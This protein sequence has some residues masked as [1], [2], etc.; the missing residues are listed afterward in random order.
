MTADAMVLAAPGG[1]AHTLKLL[2]TWSVVVSKPISPADIKAGSYI[3]TTNYAKPDGTGTSVEV[4]VS[5]P[6]QG[7][8]G[9]DFVMDAAAGT[10]MTNGTVTTVAKSEGGRVLA[11]NYGPGVRR[12]TVPDNVPV[13]LNTPGDRALVA[14]GQS[15]RVVTFTPAGG[16]AS[17]QFVTVGEKG[18]P[19]PS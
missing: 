15:V 17:R 10:T 8:P 16:G 7:G 11:V 19:P 5:P 13:V 18:A 1:L 9:V 4:H 2:P 14:V 3:G 6:G 12:V